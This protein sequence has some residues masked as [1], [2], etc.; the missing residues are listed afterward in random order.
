M[1]T[2]CT[3]CGHDIFLRFREEAFLTA[4]KLN[5][6]IKIPIK[7]KEERLWYDIKEP[8]SS[9]DRSQAKIQEKDRGKED[10]LACI[11]QGARA[12]GSLV[13]FNETRF[14]HLLRQMSAVEGEYRK[15]CNELEAAL[16]AERAHTLQLRQRVAQLE[17]ALQ[18]QDETGHRSV[19]LISGSHNT[20]SSSDSTPE[21]AAESRSETHQVLEEQERY[22]LWSSSG[23]LPVNLHITGATIEFSTVVASLACNQIVNL[24]ELGKSDHRMEH[25]EPW[26]ER[27]SAPLA[28]NSLCI[29]TAV[30]RSRGWTPGAPNATAGRTSLLEELHLW[31]LVW[32]ESRSHEL[33]SM[34]IEAN[35]RG[36]ARLKAELQKHGRG[37]LAPAIGSQHRHHQHGESDH[38]HKNSDAERTVAPSGSTRA[39]TAPP[40]ANTAGVVEAESDLRSKAPGGADAEDHRLAQVDTRELLAPG[41]KTP[42]VSEQ[43]ALLTQTQLAALLAR[44]PRRFRRCKFQLVYSTIRDGISLKTFYRKAR[45]WSSTAL[46]VQDSHYFTFGAFVTEPW[47]PNEKYQGTG[48]SFVYTLSPCMYAWRWSERNSHFMYGTNKDIAVGGCHFALHVDEEFVRGSSKACDT[49]NSPCLASAEEFNVLHVELWAFVQ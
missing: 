32:R 15:R 30:F 16:R 19:R 42:M 17:A 5:T 48:E 7:S 4:C 21:E 49:F 22:L 35:F 46:V 26:T 31:E 20:A 28:D 12:K 36:A 11:H 18:Q 3:W 13:R 14:G 34:L 9:C 6:F 25:W 41:L 38:G 39:Q 24:R 23:K 2:T 43:S 37:S 45:N 44:L 29:G 27:V 8:L 47:R 40:N 1:P 33:M 10:E